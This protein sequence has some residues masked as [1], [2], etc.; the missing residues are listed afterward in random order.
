M[1][2]EVFLCVN[3][4][5]GICTNDSYMIEILNVCLF[6]HRKFTLAEQFLDPISI[7]I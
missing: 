1:T 5:S 6:V 4:S 3:L 2:D 7:L